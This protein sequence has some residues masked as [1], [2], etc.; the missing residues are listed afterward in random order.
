LVR[1]HVDLLWRSAQYI[2]WNR[3]TSSK[4]SQTLS[5]DV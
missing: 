3:D 5:K 4:G 2:I 1:Q